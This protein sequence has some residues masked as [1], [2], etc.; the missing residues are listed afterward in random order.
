MP[1]QNFAKNCRKIV[2]SGANYK[3][4]LAATNSPTPDKPIIFFKPT[5]S[6]ITTDQTTIKVF[7]WQSCF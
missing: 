6:L 2:G 1:Y 5:S 3:S 4:F 7:V